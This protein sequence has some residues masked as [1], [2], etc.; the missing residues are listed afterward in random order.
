MNFFV[1]IFSSL[2]SIKNIYGTYVSKDSTIL[3]FGGI[4]LFL[5]GIL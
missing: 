3:P 1:F 4:V 5:L 2:Y